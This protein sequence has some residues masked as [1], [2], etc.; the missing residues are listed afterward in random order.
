[1]S[2]ESIGSCAVSLRAGRE[3]PSR[4]I[5][6]G[7]RRRCLL[8]VLLIC[9]CIYFFVRGPVRGVRISG[10]FAVF[11]TASRAWLL[12]ENPYEAGTL[13]AIFKE[14]SGEDKGVMASLNPPV[15][16]PLLAPLAILSYGSAKWLWTALNVLF[17]AL[18][19]H[20]LSRLA[21]LSTQT[22]RLLLFLSLAIALASFHTSVALGQLSV[23]LTMCMVRTME[24]DL[25]RKDYAAGILL[26]V[27]GAL[28]PQMVLVFGLY[29]LL[30]RRWR[31]VV[32]GLLAAAALIALSIGRLEIAHVPWFSSL[33]T[34]LAETTHGGIN[35]PQGSKS[36]RFLMINLQVPLHLLIDSRPVVNCLVWVF[37]GAVIVFLAAVS[38]KRQHP[39]EALLIYSC[40][41]VLSPLV[42]YSRI[43][44]ATLL[45]FP[46]AWSFAELRTQFSLIPSA[47]IFLVAPFLIP[48]VPVLL[49][50]SKFL[51]NYLTNSRLWYL[52]VLP[53]ETYVLILL[54]GCLLF[55]AIHELLRGKQEPTRPQPCPQVRSLALSRN[56]CFQDRFR[57][58]PNRL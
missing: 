54:L 11:Y 15:A 57:V 20:W 56:I 41:A 49:S 37:G 47:C 23:A 14:A 13:R 51:P 55:A 43:Y 4:L 18:S 28:K 6:R 3:Q 52:F 32:S 17:V 36:I 16:F 9:S 2:A 42:L 30:T 5:R 53:H 46:L 31:I 29:Y 58:F 38:G 25:Q 19:L 50:V 39:S 22:A 45:I 7:S 35:D 34:N 44:T 10:D 12:G 21:G 26:A 40:L 27:A 48:G 33:E 8:G 24:F 1:M